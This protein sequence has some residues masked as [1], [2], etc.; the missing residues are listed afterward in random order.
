MWNEMKEEANYTRTENGAR[1]YRSTLSGCLD[2][3]ACAGAMRQAP[4]T[5]IRGK[6]I[7]AFAEDPTLAMKIL[8][9]ARDVR[10]GL[11]ERRL[12]HTILEYLGNNKP[13]TVLK[14]LSLIPF[15]GRFDDVLPLLDTPLF[16][17]SAH[18]LKEQLE[19]DVKAMEE[20]KDN[21]SLLA[22]WL[23]SINTSNLEKVHQ[24]RRLARAFGMSE[25]TYRKTLS[26][27][28]KQL[29]LLEPRLCRKDYT[30]P[31]DEVP[32][33]AMVKYRR[34]F[35]RNDKK[36]YERFQEKVENQESTIHADTLL[37]YEIIRPLAYDYLGNRPVREKINRPMEILW[38]HQKDYAGNQN[39]LVVID[40]SGSMYSGRSPVPAMVAQSLGLYFAER[41]K[42]PFGNKFITFSETPQ[43]VEIKG[44]TLT[45]KLHYISTFDECAN[46]NLKRVFELI[47]RT[48]VKHHIPQKELPEKL[49]IISDMQF[50][51]CIEEGD[52]TNYEYA[53]KIFREAGYRLPQVIFWNVAGRTGQF[54]VTKNETGTLLVSG[55]HPVLFRQVLAG[56]TNPYD[57][58]LEIAGGKRYEPVTA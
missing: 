53:K 35:Y 20:G 49:Y 13:S 37:P 39:A 24:A 25:K 22:K 40:G 55:C 44:E 5:E 11:G 7:R 2:F 16:K 38:N 51:D 26:A 48:A 28:R 14:N 52:L 33:K 32:S 19:R 9:Y 18:F 6:F 23:P 46:T 43:L 15:Y 56:N 58:M 57:F 17:E 42:G 27:L 54:P 30:F 31:Y 21:L 45:E 3:F 34:A 4:E 50:D 8:F 29:D 36:R 41:N 12:F 10:G 1:T 47:I